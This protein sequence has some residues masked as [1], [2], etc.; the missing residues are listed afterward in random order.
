MVTRLLTGQSGDWI[1]VGARDFSLFPKHQDQLWG[2][3]N[4]LFSG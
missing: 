4:L 1:V 2:P 3:H